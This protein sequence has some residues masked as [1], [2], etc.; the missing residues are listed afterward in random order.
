MLAARVSL[1]AGSPSGAEVLGQGLV[2]AIWTDDEALSTKINSRVAHYTGQAELAAAIQD[3]LEARKQGDE[4]TATA[5][6]GRAVALAHQSGNEDT[7]KLLAKVVDVVDVETGTVRLKQAGR[8]RRRDGPGHP[9]DQDGPGEEIT[10]HAGSGYPGG[11]DGG[12][13]QRARLGERGLLRRMRHAHR[14]QVPAWR[15]HRQL[16]RHREHGQRRLRPRGWQPSGA[17]PPAR[18]PGRA[19][20]ARTRRR[21]PGE[22]CPRCG[23]ARVGQFCE[24][25]GYKFGAAQP[26]WAPAPPAP[27]PSGL[28]SGSQP[29]ATPW[30]PPSAP[31]PSAQPALAPGSAR[32][33]R[34]VGAIRASTRLRASDAARAPVRR[35]PLPPG[36]GTAGT[37]GPSGPSAL[38]TAGS[39]HSVGSVR[40]VGPLHALGPDRP[41]GLAHAPGRVLVRT[42]H[43]DRRGVRRP[44]LPRERPGRERPRRGLGAV[45]RLL[46]RTAVP[47]QRRA[48]CGSGGAACPAASIRRST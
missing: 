22:P 29:L 28:A 34:A 16:R 46:R 10:R 43:L 42:G 1:V 5:K 4:E 35:V 26:P 40:P 31:L 32:V 6:L 38:R 30:P 36:P 45:P 44:R 47:A 14:R 37:S 13:S 17:T 39:V 12:L 9:V 7:A 2:R 8:G 41:A 18:R 19:S 24:A 23:T 27:P 25:C 33:L 3:G 21:R 48:R 20:R 11:D 15:E